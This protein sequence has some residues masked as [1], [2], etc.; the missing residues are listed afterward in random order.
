MSNF[1]VLH[2]FRAPQKI[3]HGSTF[4]HWEA[5]TPSAPL[6]LLPDEAS[7]LRVDRRI[8]ELLKETSR[9][10]CSCQITQLCYRGAETCSVS[11]Q[12]SVLLHNS[13][14]LTNIA[15]TFTDQGDIPTPAVWMRKVCPCM[16]GRT[17]QRDQVF[18]PT[19][20]SV[21]CSALLLPCQQGH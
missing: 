19:G 13:Y 10:K 1:L 2:L 14:F 21:C 12:Q 4:I 18:N 5:C 15:H 20:T 8:P 16:S 9:K 6:S 3:W 7:C 11:W 17:G